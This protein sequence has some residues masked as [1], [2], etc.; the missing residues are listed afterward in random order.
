LVYAAK[1]NENMKKIIIS[2]FCLLKFK[3]KKIQKYKAMDDNSLLQ[4]NALKK[5]KKNGWGGKTMISG[6]AFLADLRGV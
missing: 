5:L 2:Q 3:G 6:R 1:G 4:K